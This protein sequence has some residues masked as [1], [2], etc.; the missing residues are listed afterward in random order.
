MQFAVNI[1]VRCSPESADDTDAAFAVIREDA[2]E[3]WALLDIGSDY[4]E[5]GRYFDYWYVEPKDEPE[6]AESAFFEAEEEITFRSNIQWIRVYGAGDNPLII[7]GPGINRNHAGCD[8][9]RYCWDGQNGEL[10]DPS[11]YR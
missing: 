10:F 3:D 8:G 6:A 1:R 5:L 11:G 7:R 4:A 9:V 2:R